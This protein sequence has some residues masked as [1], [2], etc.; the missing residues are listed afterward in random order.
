MAMPKPIALCIED[1]S[2]DPPTY[3]SCV[4]LGGHLP[5][6][7]LDPSGDVLWQRE[8]EAGFELWV[9]GDEQLMLLRC[10]GAPA[11]RVH[12]AGRFLDAPCAMPI[13]LLDGDELTIGARRLRIHV[14]G[15][16]PAVS[17]PM[18]VVVRAAGLA[19]SAASLLA[20]GAVVA[21]CDREIEVRESP[22]AVAV[23]EDAGPVGTNP[24]VS[25]DA[26]ADAGVP[27]AAAPG[28]S[29]SAPAS[30][31]AAPTGAIPSASAPIPVKTN[32]PIQVRPSPPRIAA[33]KPPSEK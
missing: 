17:A 1:L 4:A 16:A 32:Q 25:A 27:D 7:R 26:G 19:A 2:H 6:L 22:P 20:V 13:V 11:V 10:D 12:R 14:H 18:P 33:P 15:L 31:T 24:S 3:L 5:G 8:P 29:A 30:A 23:L 9:S 28:P 21:A